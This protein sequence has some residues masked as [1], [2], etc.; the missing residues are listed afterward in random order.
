MLGVSAPMYSLLIDWN[1]HQ[2]I[3]KLHHY[4]FIVIRISLEKGTYL[5]VAFVWN[6]FPQIKLKTIH[7]Y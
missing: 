3:I 7:L 1:V 6:I 4:Y 5:I 2:V